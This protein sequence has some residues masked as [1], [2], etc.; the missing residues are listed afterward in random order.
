MAELGFVLSARKAAQIMG[1]NP[2]TIR[3]AI[4]NGTFPFGERYKGNGEWIYAISTRKL[5]D[6][7]GIT[8]AEALERIN[9]KK[10]A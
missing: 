5:L 4:D 10:G 9:I 1:K 2:D 3:A 6:F 7:L 8:E